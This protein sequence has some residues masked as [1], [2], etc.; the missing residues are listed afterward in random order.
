[1][2]NFGTLAFRP[3]SPE[4]ESFL[5]DLYSSTRAEELKSWGWDTQQQSQFLRMQFN[6]QQQSYRAYFPNNYYQI[7]MNDGCLIGSMLVVRNKKEIRIADI[8]LLP[9]YQNQGIGTYLI[10][11]LLIEAQHIK[12]PVSLQV[13]KW[14]RAVHLYE[15]LGFEKIDD[16]GIYLLM[17]WR[18]FSN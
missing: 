5:F 10:Q 1:M 16:T 4:D 13:V 12:K 6:A 17:E 8:A 7:I 2:F 3:A 14:N 9:A 18:K 11:N 15:R